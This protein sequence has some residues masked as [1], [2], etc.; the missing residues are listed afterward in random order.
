MW[1]RGRRPGAGGAAHLLAY[2]IPLHAVI[3]KFGENH[4]TRWVPEPLRT[5]PPTS[6][7]ATLATTALRSAA[8]WRWR[9]VQR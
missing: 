5:G 6:C 9:R 1:E 3:V 7:A 2:S 4:Q 8:S